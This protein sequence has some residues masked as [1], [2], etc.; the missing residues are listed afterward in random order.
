MEGGFSITGKSDNVQGLVMAFH[1]CQLGLE[2]V[3]YFLAC[4]ENGV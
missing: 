3:V 1:V 2:G 4:R